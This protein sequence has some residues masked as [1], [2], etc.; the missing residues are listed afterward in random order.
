MRYRNDPDG[1]RL[2]IK[3]DTTTNGEFSPRPLDRHNHAANT[4]AL[5]RADENARRKNL[6]RRSFLTSACGAAS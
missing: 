4:L 6:S 3:V 5:T 2:P 1:I